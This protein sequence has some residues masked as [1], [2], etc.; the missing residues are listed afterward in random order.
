MCNRKTR[1]ALRLTTEAYP[2]IARPLAA[3]TFQ[4]VVPGRRFSLRIGLGLASATE[5]A[6]LAAPLFTLPPESTLGLA[7]LG[8][9]TQSGSARTIAAAMAGKTFFTRRLLH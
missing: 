7:S 5:L 3:G 9:G 1:P 8:I 6:T 4:A 2:S